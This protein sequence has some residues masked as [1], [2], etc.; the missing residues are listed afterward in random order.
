VAAGADHVVPIPSR[1][2]GRHPHLYYGLTACD[3]GWGKRRPRQVLGGQPTRGARVAL[4]AWPF[5][6]AP[7][8]PPP[9]WRRPSTWVVLALSAACVVL[10]RVLAR[11][12]RRRRWPTFGA[13]PADK[14]LA[15]IYYQL[16]KSLSAPLAEPAGA[17]T[18]APEAPVAPPPAPAA[19]APLPAPPPTP[20][21]LPAPLPAT[22]EAA[23]EEEKRGFGWL[24]SRGKAP[25][26]AALAELLQ[27]A[28]LEPHKKFVSAVASE[29]SVDAPEGAF[30]DVPG[31]TAVPAAV[32]KS[33]RTAL[34]HAA[35]KSEAEQIKPVKRAELVVQVAK[36]MVLVLVDRAAALKENE[37]LLGALDNL[38]GFAADAARLCEELAP[39]VEAAKVTY[40]G[41]LRHKKL[42]ELYSAYLDTSVQE[43]SRL[44][45]S[46]MGGLGL[47]QGQPYA[48]MEKMQAHVDQRDK[49]STILASVF[50]ISEGKAER[51]MEKKMKNLFSE[52]VAKDMFK[53]LPGMT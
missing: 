1:C 44:V 6:T 4:L 49:N 46:L 43:A 35:V 14:P 15:D 47:E 42:E 7:P 22:S 29:L 41:Q 9:L 11:R 53:G 36:S 24:T 33:A 52:D 21:P 31:L 26:V 28:T 50:K 48:G 17:A 23:V 20:A 2:R 27:D 19:T 3:S 37:A 25:K 39:D 45:T 5:M 16:E 10:I 13:R 12:S 30:D 40:E 34:L 8:P 32:P 51:L 18:E 38:V